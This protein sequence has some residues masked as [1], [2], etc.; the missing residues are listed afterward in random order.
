MLLNSCKVQQMDQY[1][2]SD[3]N[4]NAEESKKIVEAQ[5]EKTEINTFNDFGKPE[6]K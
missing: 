4:R 2:T 6:A 5:R 1:P 3:L